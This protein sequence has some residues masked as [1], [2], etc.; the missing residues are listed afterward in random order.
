VARSGAIFGSVVNLRSGLLPTQVSETSLC[1]SH[2]V[3]PTT[4]RPKSQPASWSYGFRVSSL[5]PSREVLVWGF[6]RMGQPEDRLAKKL[7][8]LVWSGSK[9]AAPFA[10][11]RVKVYK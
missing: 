9:S 4:V 11:T 10:E 1:L 7:A 8:N 3:S 6:S 5:A 2:W